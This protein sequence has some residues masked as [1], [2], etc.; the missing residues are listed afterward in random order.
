[1]RAPPPL[2][3][4]AALSSACVQTPD[5]IVTVELATADPLSRPVTA[6]LVVQFQTTVTWDGLASDPQLLYA[7]TVDGAAPPFDQPT[8]ASLRFEGGTGETDL[9]EGAVTSSAVD[10]AVVGYTTDSAL[11]FARHTFTLTCKRAGTAQLTFTARAGV[12]DDD[13]EDQA[14]SSVTCVAEGGDTDT[15]LDTDAGSGAWTWLLVR[16][17]TNAPTDGAGMKVDAF[18]WYT[19][20]EDVYAAE[21]TCTPGSAQDGTHADCSQTAGPKTPHVN[22][23]PGSATDWYSVGGANGEIVARFEPPTG[24]ADAPT[25]FEAGH[26]LTVHDCTNAFDATEPTFEMAIGKSASG[27]WRTLTPTGQESYILTAADVE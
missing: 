3:L 27:P 23:C 20:Q 2:L 15:D 1:M 25:G 9:A 12:R 14:T 24:R 13:P 6:D 10:G 16:D 17:R 21:T 19:L 4:A 5:A 11:T 26:V 18:Q 7:L 22:P 8:L